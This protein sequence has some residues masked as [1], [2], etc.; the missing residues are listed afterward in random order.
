MSKK[1][2]VVTVLGTRPEI[3]KMSSL[4]KLLDYYTNHIIVHTG[5]NYDY[6]LNSVFF[7]DLELRE[8]DYFLETGGK[9]FIPTIANIL[10]KIENVLKEVKPDALVVYGDTNSCLS[11]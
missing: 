4:L 3:I 9:S 6:E 2:K 1:F 7:S 10:T 11:V 5:Q 8:P